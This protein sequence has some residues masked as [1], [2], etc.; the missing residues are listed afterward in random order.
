MNSLF[1][2]TL[3]TL[4]L[5]WNQIGEKGAEY[6]AKALQQNNVTFITLFDL[7]YNYAF[8]V[9]IDTHNTKSATELCQR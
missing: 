2:Q 6:F 7:P 3:K 4:Q 9:F 8:I 1:S 5:A